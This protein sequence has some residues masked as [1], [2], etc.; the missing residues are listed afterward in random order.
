MSATSS[1]V[2][3]SDLDGTLLDPDSSSIDGARPGIDMLRANQVPL[4][5][6]SSQTRAEIQL[7]Q[8]EIGVNHPFVSEN[9]G[10]LYIPDGYFGF[11]ALRTPPIAGYQIVE[12]GRP[13]AE[14]VDILRRTADRLH[15]DIVGFSDMSIEQVASECGLPLMQARLA[16]LREYD[17]P[18][19]FVGDDSDTRARLTKALQ[20]ARLACTDCGRFDH[21]GAPVN[22]G[23]AVGLIGALYERARRPTLTI[24]LGDSPSDVSFLRQVDVPIVVHHGDVNA[25]AGMLDQIPAAR[26][27]RAPG[28]AGWSEAITEVVGDALN[29]RMPVPAVALTR[30]RR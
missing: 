3:F 15:I 5:I 6:C 14:V 20:S 19:R 18:F 8:Q 1:I 25:V 21:A 27:T 2:V 24:G 7:L 29:G 13:H 26:L 11:D 28:P 10:A 16:K 30:R 12:Y 22:K 9:G 17:E 23:I 4:V